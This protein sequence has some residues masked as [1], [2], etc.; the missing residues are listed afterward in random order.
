[1]DSIILIIIGIIAGAILGV[2]VL[3]AFKKE[4]SEEEQIAKIL[5]EMENL[6]NKV[7]QGVL[8]NTSEQLT[9][10]FTNQS[11]QFT[12]QF[13]ELAKE[14]LDNTAE[15]VKSDLEAKKDSIAVLVNEIRKE[16]GKNEEHL[17]KSDIDRVSAFSSLQEELKNY[18]QITGELKNSTEGLKR[19][20][21]NNQERGRFGEQV[22]ENLLKMS[23][24]VIGTDYVYNKEQ[25]NVD[26]RPDFTIFL[27]DKTKINIDVKFPYSAL[28]KYTEV[29][30]KLEKEQHLKQFT[31]DIKQK[32]KQ[33]TT[34]DYINP[35]DRTVDFVVMFIPNEMIFSF[36]YE[37][38]NDTWEDAMA[39]KVIMAGPFSFTAILR[40][41]KQA[42]SNFRY[43][44]N[45]HHIIGLIQN[46]DKE[47]QKYSKEVDILGNRI[48]SAS[49][50]F[51]QV[52][53]TRNRALVK[54]IDQIKNEKIQ[55]SP[56]LGGD[57]VK[58]DKKLKLN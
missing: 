4:P 25:G 20:L 39:K 35:E 24:F 1:M 36:I 9:T 29:E 51:D 16:I 7:S 18:K 48:S 30:G 2:A 56:S 5:P 12:N 44:E 41:V 52:S 54:I 26:T 28:V 17:K 15:K 37:K 53:I 38:L 43:Q 21:S 32:I 49:K 47:Y 58:I 13:Q 42:Y 33:V 55:A 27:P 31:T 10:Q 19:L 8:K 22:A 45:L 23:G 40:M 3:K 34:R 14:K 57:D 50:Q 46:F 6:F 11:I